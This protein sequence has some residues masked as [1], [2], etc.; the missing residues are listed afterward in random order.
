MTSTPEIVKPNAD[1]SN[2]RKSGVSAGTIA[3]AVIGAVV[4]VALILAGAFFLWRR[5]RNAA[6]GPSGTAS[7]GS[8]RKME[9]NESVLSKT[10]L[11]AAAGVG[12]G[13]G[14]GGS[15]GNDVEKSS[16][17]APPYINTSMNRRQSGMNQTNGPSPTSP[18]VFDGDS[19]LSRR[20]SRPLVY[21][22][23]LNPQAIMSNWEANGSRA[24]VGTMQDQRDYSRPLGVTNPDPIDD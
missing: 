23:R 24:S 10:G 12:S 9:R 21:D 1:T 6:A 19:Q 3:G 5:R 4:G 13:A 22:Q 15:G 8:R 7:P 11:L 20:N 16:Y 2:S 18:I 14:A 17:D